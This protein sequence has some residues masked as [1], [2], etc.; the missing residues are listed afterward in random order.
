MSIIKKLS[1]VLHSV[2]ECM[3]TGH[4]HINKKL[5]YRLC[6]SNGVADLLKHAPPH[7]GCHAE[8]GRSTPN[9]RPTSV[10]KEIRLKI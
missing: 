8:F 7:I 6:K 1:I 9:G 5:S 10:I 2:A 4:V 3:Y